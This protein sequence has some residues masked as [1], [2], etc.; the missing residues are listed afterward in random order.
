ME[1][2]NNKN[3]VYHVLNH[4][5]IHK[6]NFHIIE[7][8]LRYYLLT[9]NEIIPYCYTILLAGI[10]KKRIINAQ[11]SDLKTFDSRHAKA[12]IFSLM[13]IVVYL[14]HIHQRYPNQTFKQC[15]EI[16]NLIMIF[17]YY[18]NYVIQF[19]EKYKNVFTKNVK[20]S[21]SIFSKIDN[22]ISK[23]KS[24]SN[25]D[26][27]YQYCNDWINKLINFF[28]IDEKEYRNKIVAEICNDYYITNFVNEFNKATIHHY[29]FFKL[30]VQELNEK[31]RSCSIKLFIE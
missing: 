7:D 26:Y 29:V 18:R 9:S 4:L 22:E 19:I 1:Y 3:H 6:D 31:Y 15:N 5:Y 27:Q 2:V 24:Y 10:M 14:H 25:S 21:L 13:S 11:Q 16:N 17:E 28:F 12:N 23:S 20:K 30:S 8:Y